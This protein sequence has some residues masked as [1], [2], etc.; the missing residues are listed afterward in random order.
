MTNLTVEQAR[1]MILKE[2]RRQA[3]VSNEA[4]AMTAAVKKCPHC[5]RKWHPP[6]DCWKLHPEKTPD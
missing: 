6:D 4:L 5:K 2:E 1:N 3:N